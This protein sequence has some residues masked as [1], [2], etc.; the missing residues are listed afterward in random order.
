[1]K[2]SLIKTASSI[3]N[4]LSVNNLKKKFNKKPI[5]TWIV[6]SLILIVA[7]Y[8]IRPIFLNF[9]FEREFIENKINREFNFSGKIKGEIKYNFLPSPRITINKMEIKFNDSSRKS[10][11]VDVSHILISPFYLS[12]IKKFKF[13]NFLILNQKLEVYPKEIKNYLIFFSKP[14]TKNFLI[15]NSEVY[16]L[17]SQKEKVLFTNFNLSQR[18]KKTQNKIDLN[19]I[20]SQKKLKIK[21]LDDYKNKKYFK[22]SIPAIESSVDI[23]F[24]PNS[25]LED[26]SGQLKLDLLDGILLMNFNGSKDFKILNSFLRNKFLNSKVNGKISFKDGFFFDLNL[27]VNKINLR[28]LLF[29]YFAPTESQNQIIS[30]LS[31]KI[32]GQIKINNR[33]SNSFMGRLNNSKATLIFESGKLKI[34]NGSTTFFDGSK[35]NFKCLLGDSSGS[36]QLDFTINFSSSNAKKFLKKLDLYNYNENNLEILLKG[37]INLQERKIRI[38][39]IIKNNNERISRGEIMQIEKKFNTYVIKD[40]VLDFLDFFK[41]KKFTNES[42]NNE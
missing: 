5:I 15:K 36:P 18:T 13:K 32:N 42:F 7:S 35:L 8:F 21:F 40:N 12:N 41:I 22:A 4:S 2:T 19:T 10:S 26:L 38:S 24:D 28:Q 9:N 39:N 30:G 37:V 1:M 25:T 11:E 34:E 29:Y 23:I 20:F 31:K 16:F 6:V 17:N 3:F 33:T 14:K 27:D